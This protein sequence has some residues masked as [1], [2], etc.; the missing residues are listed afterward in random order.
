MSP[1]LKNRALTRLRRRSRRRAFLPSLAL[2]DVRYESVRHSGIE[3]ATQ[4][5]RWM[6]VSP[7]GEVQGGR[8]P[9][10]NSSSRTRASGLQVL[11]ARSP[12]VVRSSSIGL[13]LDLYVIRVCIGYL[14]RKGCWILMSI[15]LMYINIPVYTYIML[16]IQGLRTRAPQ[17]PSP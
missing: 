3:L 13:H 15:V 16:Y 14:S 11:Q 10:K 17:A 5:H 2:H 9:Q 8:K 12:S 1:G 4:G 7:R 6:Q